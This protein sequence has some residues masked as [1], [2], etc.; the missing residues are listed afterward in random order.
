MAV[1]VVAALVFAATAF[2]GKPTSSLE[3]VVLPSGTAAAATTTS[4][5][6]YGGQITFDVLTTQ[7][8]HPTVNVRCFQDG[9]WVYDGWE[10]FWEDYVPEP[11]YT[12]SSGY[13]TSG[14]ADC[15]AR[16]VY[17]DRHGRVR[18]LTSMDFH[19]TA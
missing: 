17:V 3:L 7:T 1:G 12:L 8:D 2:A 18:E 6:S 16:L 10:S 9:A 5:P 19:V 15:T 11:V 4:E 13:W 14:A